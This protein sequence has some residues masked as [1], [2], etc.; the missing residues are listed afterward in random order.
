MAF[1]T[2]A[3]EK[4]IGYWSSLLPYNTTYGM[5]TDGSLIF[6]ICQQAFFTMDPA[7][8]ETTTYSKVN[9]MSD[10]GMQCVAYDKKS[11]T[12]VLGY[13]NS[14]IDLFKNNTF[15]NIPDLK[16]KTVAGDKKINSVYTENGKAY[17]STSLGVVVIDL[18]EQSFEETYQF[19]VNNQLLAIN[20]FTAYNGYF[21]AA[22][23][24]GLYRASKN[25]PQL[26]NFQVWQRIDSV[27]VF[28]DIQVLNNKLTMSTSH[29]I[30]QLQS[31]TAAAVYTNDTVGITGIDGGNNN[32]FIR[33]FGKVRIMDTFFSQVDSIVFVDS[34]TKVIQLPDGNIWI[35]GMYHGLAWSPLSGRYFPNTPNGPSDPNSYDIY[36]HNRDIWVAHGGFDDVYHANNNLTGFSNLRNDKWRQFSTYNYPPISYKTLDFVSITKDENDGT[37]YAGSFSGGLFELKAN[38]SNTTYKDGS[39]LEPS[40][41]NGSIDFY[42]VVGTGIDKD[43]NLWVTMFG[44]FHELYV[45]EKATAN[46]YKYHLNYTRNYPNAG[47]PLV[48]DNSG[49]VWYLCRYG[50]GV[51]GYDTKGTFSDPS[52]DVTYHMT[53]GGGV[54]NLPD[55][56][57]RSIAIDKNDN[58]WIG[59]VNGIG[60][61]YNASSCLAQ[62]CDAEIPIVQYDKYAGYLFAGETVQSIAVDGANRKWIGTNNGVWLLSPDAGNSK[63]IY[64]FTTDNSPLPSNKIQKIT[65][66][67]VTGDV[68]IGTDQGL[69]CYR[70]TAT[71]GAETASTVVTFPN[72]VPTNYK[73]TIAIKGLTANADVRITDINGQLVY[74][75]TALGGQAVWN[76]LDYKGHRPQS[77]VYLIFASNTD[78]SQTYAGKMVFMN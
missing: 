29:I 68:Y 72:P 17:F 24:N 34:F 57:V 11:N 40:I 78:G 19:F 5:A 4:P 23:P 30:Y 74:R 39:A 45:R 44:S 49:H 25:N 65:I 27:H 50:G 67:D 22:T 8:L 53:G 36:A 61:L 15:Y 9:G 47:G 31:D 1:V 63:I 35:G 18:D 6:N 42:Q 46:W 16:L 37:V 7:T 75:T 51:I 10:I 28:K 2:H 60:I 3:Q 73:G 70:S 64:R 56:D 12:V 71:E 38:D 54:G 33:Q 21:Y 77:G 26:Q 76:G 43:D 52:D 62:R 41:P 13:T 58:L 66:D 20:S 69:M 32:Y 59:T 14:N 48:F 55:A